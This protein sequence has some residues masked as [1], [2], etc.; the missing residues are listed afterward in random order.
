MKELD[1]SSSSPS[2]RSMRS[3]MSRMLRRLRCFPWGVAGAETCCVV[4]FLTT[5]SS[6]IKSK[7]FTCRVSSPSQVLLSAVVQVSPESV[8]SLRVNSMVGSDTLRRCGLGTSAFL[9]KD[10]KDPALKKA[11]SS[12]P[13]HPTVLRRGSRCGLVGADFV[14][15]AV[16]V[17]RCFMVLLCWSCSWESR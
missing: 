8:L 12:P 14:R 15:G 6:S 9:K 16:R 2:R 11:S 4:Q 10:R 1:S 3:I 5:N 13:S 17:W 7:R